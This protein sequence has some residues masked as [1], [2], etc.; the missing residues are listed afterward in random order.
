[1]L[2]L[3]PIESIS[4]AEDRKDDI[5]SP[6]SDAQPMSHGVE[7]MPASSPIAAAQQLAQLSNAAAG[8]P[9]YALWL[10]LQ[11]QSALA[12]MPTVDPSLAPF[13]LDASPMD[14]VPQPSPSVHSDLSTAYLQNPSMTDMHHFT[15]NPA[16]ASMTMPGW[17]GLPFLPVG[18]GQ[19]PGFAPHM[20]SHMYDQSLMA[21]R[22]PASV[23]QHV[24]SLAFAQAPMPGLADQGLSPAWAMNYG[25]PP[26][27]YP[28]ESFCDL[29]LLSAQT[30]THS[31]CSDHVT[32]VFRVQPGQISASTGDLLYNRTTLC[33]TV[34]AGCL[35]PHICNVI[36][37]VYS[38][39]EE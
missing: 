33:F 35:L 19:L 7:D 8:I 9:G 15:P 5:A 37:S 2:L 39:V 17:G 12:K 30:L 6:A 11:Y 31:V 25:V 24:N 13:P 16:Q 38:L 21:S 3:Q 4:I 10:Q 1:M 29:S 18:A 27:Q 36:R 23:A 32:S 26:A 22:A 34:V 20:Q 14:T 28:G